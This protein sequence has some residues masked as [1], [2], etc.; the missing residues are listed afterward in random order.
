M[1]ASYEVQ[2]LGAVP[3]GD[4]LLTCRFSRPENYTFRAG[5]WFRLTLVTPQGEITKTFSHCSSPH[6]PDLEMTTRLSGSPFKDAL[7]VL[8]PGDRVRI[9]GPGGQLNIPGDID[10]FCFLAGGVGITPVRSLL[11][12]ARHTGRAFADALLLYANR[13]ESC[14]P[15]AEEFLLMGGM[16]VRMVLCFEH[17]SESWAGERGFVTAGTVRR[18]IDLLDGRAFVVAGPPVM[19]TAMEGVLDELGISEGLRIV[20]RFGSPTA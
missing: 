19:V 14:V 9:T 10:R 15:F 16:G 17:A 2:L 6:D 8:V 20:E 5:Q 1:S 7:K 11:R 13:D 12:D 3:C 18:H 4:D